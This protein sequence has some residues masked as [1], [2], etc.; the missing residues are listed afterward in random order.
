MLA[1]AGMPL[2]RDTARHAR[3]M[4]FVGLLGVVAHQMNVPSSVAADEIVSWPGSWLGEGPGPLNSHPV[5]R[6]WSDLLS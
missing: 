5:L 3:V 2:E 6:D 1:G 4:Q